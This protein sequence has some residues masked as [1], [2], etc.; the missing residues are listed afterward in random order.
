MTYLISGIGL[1][2]V[3]TPALLFFAM[4]VSGVVHGRLKREPNEPWIVFREQPVKFMAIIT[5]YL[6]FAFLFTV[7]SV[8]VASS[9]LR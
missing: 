9:L 1:S 4:A 7:A 8:R 2:M 6:T 5:A 3:V